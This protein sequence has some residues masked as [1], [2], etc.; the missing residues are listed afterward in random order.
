[1]CNM[2]GM[3]LPV[4]GRSRLN[5]RLRGERGERSPYLLKPNVR[6]LVLVFTLLTKITE[7]GM[8]NKSG[9]YLLP[10]P[11]ECRARGQS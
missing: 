10:L 6:G 9:S 4:L 8:V 7:Y 11:I 3:L 1:M 2:T 5:I